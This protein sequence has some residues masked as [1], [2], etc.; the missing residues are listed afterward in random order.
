MTDDNFPLKP[1][2]YLYDND[3]TY[4]LLKFENVDGS[5]AS[6]FSEIAF[7]I[8]DINL[9]DCFTPDG[10]EWG[11]QWTTK[12]IN[13]FW[14]LSRTHLLNNSEINGQA[15]GFEPKFKATVIPWNDD[16]VLG[17][18]GVWNIKIPKNKTVTVTWLALDLVNEDEG[19]KETG[20]PE[21]LPSCITWSKQARIFTAGNEDLIVTVD[22]GYQLLFNSL[23]IANGGTLELVIPDSMDINKV[24]KIALY[25]HLDSIL[26]LIN[27]KIA[28]T[29][30]EVLTGITAKVTSQ[31]QMY[32][33]ARVHPAYTLNPFKF[34]P[35]QDNRLVDESVD[36][37]APTFQQVPNNYYFCGLV[38]A[39]NNAWNN[40]KVGT[41]IGKKIGIKYFT[42]SKSINLYFVDYQLNDIFDREPN[43]NILGYDVYNPG[44]SVGRFNGIDYIRSDGQ[45]TYPNV[46]NL[47][48]PTGKVLEIDHPRYSLFT[49]ESNQP[50]DSEWEK[51]TPSPYKPLFAMSSYPNLFTDGGQ[52]PVS[53]NGTKPFY[54]F[55]FYYQG[56][57]DTNRY[58][59]WD[60]YFYSNP[61]SVTFVYDAY[62]HQ[63]RI[64]GVVIPFLGLDYSLFESGQVAI[65]RNSHELILNGNVRVTNDV[66]EYIGERKEVK[67][68]TA[69]KINVINQTPESPLINY[70]LTNT[71]EDGF[72]A[73]GGY[74]GVDWEESNQWNYFITETMEQ[75]INLRRDLRLTPIQIPDA[76]EVSNG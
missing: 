70:S 51:T 26:A 44:Y 59:C 54:N 42:N 13:A 2:L 61:E 76:I 68:K 56:K 37:F 72:S 9:I 40:G 25:E 27:S 24:R 5:I 14:K 62:L 23:V 22:L 28:L 15:Y 38:K 33:G 46:T 36:F 1:A 71:T 3:Q 52:Y 63:T 57:T 41:D 73:S 31:F 48:V 69:I 30:C 8:N 74:D 35:G 10:Y 75:S 67:Q 4:D 49:L 17:L 45:Y 47:T 21:N 32:Q 34:S 20:Y 11:D 65:I 19:D 6:L 53:I 39:N 50:I 60:N 7:E 43:N 55:R 12:F 66:S 18:G 29:E 64:T 58:A 16:D